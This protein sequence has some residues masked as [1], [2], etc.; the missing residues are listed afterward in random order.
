M[1]GWTRFAILLALYA[2]V[3]V[4]TECMSDAATT[5]L[6]APLAA[7]MAQGLGHAPE[8]YVVTVAVAAVGAALTPMADH[9][10]LVIADAGGYRF[11]DFARAGTRPTA[12]VGLVVATLA[13]LL[14][15]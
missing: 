6:L 15:G 8:P 7:A 3:A 12:L 5:A 10:N 11:W 9:G 13:P 1:S 2:V 4:I 14:R